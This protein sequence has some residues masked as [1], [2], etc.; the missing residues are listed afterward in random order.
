MKRARSASVIPGFNLQNLFLSIRLAAQ[1]PIE[2]STPHEKWCSPDEPY[3]LYHRYEFVVAGRYFLVEVPLKE[4]ATEVE[5][6]AGR[7]MVR[8]RFLDRFEK[9]YLPEQAAAE[10]REAIYRAPVACSN[11]AYG[12]GSYYCLQDVARLLP[13]CPRCRRCDLPYPRWKNVSTLDHVHRR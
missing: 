12:H 6:V 13:K 10:V 3:H 2:I 4:A 9:Y 7:T 8:E 11:N 1:A 5:R